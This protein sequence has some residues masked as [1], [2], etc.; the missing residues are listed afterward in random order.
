[1][2][3]MLI[4][5]VLLQIA[6]QQSPGSGQCGL[7][8]GAVAN[9]INSTEPWYC[10]INN[11][12]YQSWLNYL[13]ILVIVTLI[14]FM[15][16][17]II[18]MTG[19][20]LQ[21]PRIRNFGVSELYEAMATAII[22]GAFVYVCAVLFG[23]TPGSVV[24]A[25]NP[26][27]TS[28]KLISSTINTASSAYTTLYQIYVP[29]ATVASFSFSLD[30]TLTGLFQGQAYSLLQKYALVPQL[31][32]QVGGYAIQLLLLEPS[33][34]IAKFLLD[35]ISLLYSEYYLLV[36]FAVAS[37]PAFLIPGVIF[38]ALFPTRA[39]GGVLIAMAIGFYLVMPTLFAAVYY[40][41]APGLMASINT[42][43]AQMKQFGLSASTSSILSPA[44]PLVASI[45]N[46]QTA[47]DGFW[48]LILF[49][50]VLIIAVTYSFIAQLAQF[51][52]GS[53]RTV[54]RLRSFI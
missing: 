10:P 35:G 51:I 33:L 50:P 49:Y 5:F 46:T 54:N 36:F 15:I 22:V 42:A 45:N 2:L 7:L 14:A 34:A 1:M 12:I 39:L 11:Q 53:Y 47:L 44:N 26:Y 37:I 6:N 3:H 31:I 48:M 17:A 30:G 52:G 38:R 43:N 23:V 40:F 13:P 8:P 32:S 16:A 20:V 19:V 25:I 29:W 41:T 9:I 24:G 28:F 4:P 27:A 21:S 18:F